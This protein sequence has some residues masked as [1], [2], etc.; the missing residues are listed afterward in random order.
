MTH[1]SH[2]TPL[3][4]RILR[5]GVAVGVAH[6]LFKF[7]GLI[8]AKAM[9]HFVPKDVYDVVYVFAFENCIFSIFL[10]GEEVI[11]PAFL[12][13]FMGELDEQGERP[14]WQ[15]ANRI[16]SWQFLIL[17]GVIA[18]LVLAPATVVRL[19][20]EWEPE[21][22]PATF[23]LAV[24]CVR[25]LSPAL[26]GL[27]IGSTTYMLLNGYKRFF[28]AA[29]GDAVWK[30]CVVLVLLIGMGIMA[31][32]SE[33][34]LLGLLIGSLLKLAT[35]L[36][37]LRDKLG[38]LRFRFSGNSPA[39]KR[40]LMLA[41]PLIIG[42]VFAKIRDVFNNVTIL[43]HLEQAGLMQAN[44]MGRK[45]MSSITWLVPYTLAIAMFPFFCEMVDR[46][47]RRQLGDVLT[48]SARML[49]SVLTP[50]AAV[51]AVVA[52]P[53]TAL[54]FRGGEFDDTAVALTSISLACYTLIIPAAALET[55]VMQA[56]FADRRMVSVTVIGI[57]F[58]ALSMLIS[59]V[60]VI[61]FELTG[62][63]ALAVVAGGF[64]LSRILK[65]TALVLLLKRSA[66]VFPA[67][68]TASF[69]VR[70]A[71]LTA[72]CAALAWLGMRGA[73]YLQVDPATW[74][75]PLTALALAGAGAAIAFGAG[76][77]VFRVREP[78]TM[79]QWALERRRGAQPSQEQP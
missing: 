56:F 39:M 6:L 10:L 58:S 8:Q 42:I 37:G 44:S 51:A 18:L 67:A 45:L 41:L 21:T 63:P 61:H 48:N 72:L 23:A 59:F 24:A 15:F 3:A 4:R 79:I 13:V 54:L 27:S 38:K 76:C 62:G 12:P 19:W 17:L 73:G 25:A 9:G 14:A 57:V 40:M 77:F 49:L 16:L 32:G 74:K 68:P 1:S 5:A 66:P 43:S 70:T 35:H 29:F 64:A 78:W 55:I 47:D 2:C 7:A 34:L 22:H 75:G 30:F 60:G 52:R 53:L 31:L 26:L 20:T 71:L 36:V 28:L 46:N 50:V 33:M 65:S 11:G 69:L